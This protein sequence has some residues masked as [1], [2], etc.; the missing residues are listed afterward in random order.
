[1]SVRSYGARKALML[2]CLAMAGLV[3]AAAAH[4]AGSVAADTFAQGRDAGRVPAAPRDAFAA[5]F[6]VALERPVAMDAHLAGF[7]VTV[8][9]DA[10]IGGDLY[11][12]GGSVEVRAAVADDVTLAGA[13]VALGAAA[14]VGGNA[15]VVAGD[16]TLDAPVAGDL[17][18]GAGRIVLNATIG[19]DVR[20]AA[21]EI[22]FGENA[23][24]V[25]TLRYAA[26]SRVDVPAS[27]AAADRIVRTALER[28]DVREWGRTA[29]D[30]MPGARTFV[31][32]ALFG[33]L[34]T[35]L[36]LLAVA[37]LLFAFAPLRT[38]RLRGYAARHP[39]H[40]V[41]MGFLGLATVVGLVPV[42]LLTLVGIP[43]VPIALLGIFLFW[44]IGY[45]LGV[46][47][48]ACRIWG[49]DEPSTRSVASRLGVLAL[50]IVAFAALNF[51]PFVG[52]LINLALML[53]GLGA[54]STAIAVRLVTRPDASGERRLLLTHEPRADAA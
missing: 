46:Y 33:T 29:R 8:G 44:T 24:V 12:T 47:V 48:V 26:P 41:M 3:Q 27:V 9:P 36:F 49:A 50:G 54:M 5:G 22:V 18:A 45:V 43:L 17:T 42:G 16:L 38:E 37:A 20:L 10:D 51:V 28:E 6:S 19:G 23:R 31:S 30:S 53:L 15:R 39:W 21:S 25:G 11:A 35:L 52:W 14:S 4:A 32:S 40:A 7:D 34:V 1:M 13:T 2:A